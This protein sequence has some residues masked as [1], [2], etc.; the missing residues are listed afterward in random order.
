MIPFMEA[1][2][3]TIDDDALEYEPIEYDPIVDG[4]IDKYSF[5]LARKNYLLYAERYPD[6]LSKFSNREIRLRFIANL[7]FILFHLAS[8]LL[9]FTL[10]PNK[11]KT[12]ENAIAPK[13]KRLLI[14][15]FDGNEVGLYKVMHYSCA[16]FRWEEMSSREQKRF[17]A[18]YREVELSA[19]HALIFWSGGYADKSVIDA[20][21]VFLDDRN[22]D[23]SNNDNMQIPARR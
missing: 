6:V 4:K 11:E 14:G 19:F 16:I 17:R 7:Y 2:D 23:A 10:L 9:F 13:L 22:L 3:E 12:F 8:K 5:K 20:F 18:L 21:D 15:T 1:N